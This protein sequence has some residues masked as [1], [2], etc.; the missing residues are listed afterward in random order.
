MRL[1]EFDAADPNNRKPALSLRHI[2]RLK[3]LKAERRKEFAKRKVVMGLMYGQDDPR[4][5]DLA[6]RELDHGR[7]ELELD[8]REAELDLLDQQ[9]RQ[10]EK[11]HGHIQKM[12]KRWITKN[13]GRTTTSLHRPFLGFP[14][15]PKTTLHLAVIRGYSHS[16]GNTLIQAIRHSLVNDDVVTSPC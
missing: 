13:D 11:S 10:S 8:K 6:K 14:A 15:A 7:R 1:Y 3:K 5:I 9:I 2:N 4:E 16:Q 12:A